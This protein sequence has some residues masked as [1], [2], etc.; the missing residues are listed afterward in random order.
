MF[1]D[2]QC[3]FN[4]LCLS[5]CTNGRMDT[6]N[7]PVTNSVLTVRFSKL[8]FFCERFDTETYLSYFLSVYLYAFPTVYSPVLSSETL[9]Q[10]PVI[11]TILSLEFFLYF[12]ERSDLYLLYFC[13]SYCP[14]YNNFVK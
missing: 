4:P 9:F 8:F 2:L 14:F 1:R 11:L 5:V 3:I 6:Q 10:L 7:R 12:F 13:L